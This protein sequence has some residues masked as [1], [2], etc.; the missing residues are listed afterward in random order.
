MVKGQSAATA[1]VFA[2]EGKVPVQKV[3]YAK[4]KERLLADAQILEW[5]GPMKTVGGNF[6]VKDLGG[7]V[8]DDAQ[9]EFVGDWTFSSASRAVAVGY[10]HDG[11]ANKGSA[12]AVFRPEIPKDGEYE[13][14][15]LYPPLGNRASDVPVN[16][17]TEGQEWTVHVNQRSAG[18]YQEQSLGR[19]H[20]K[21]GKTLAVTVS[22]ASTDGYV[23]VDGL[24]LL[25]V[26]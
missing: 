22:N 7:V 26:H 18:K 24:Q 12:K 20:L 9:A 14:F 23:V 3:D 11:N 16:L 5:T 17:A 25:L 10:M 4:L 13:V 8:V 15:L 1:A 6:D 21:A 19:V 2:I